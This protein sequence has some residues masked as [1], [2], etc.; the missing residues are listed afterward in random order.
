[1]LEPIDQVSPATESVGGTNPKASK[2]HQITGFPKWQ[3]WST[4][5]LAYGTP[6]M[7]DVVIYSIDVARVM[8]ELVEKYGVDSQML[9]LEITETAFL[10]KPDKYENIVSELRQKGFLVE[11]DDFGK[12]NSTL[13]FL[14]DIKADVLKI[15][16]S[17]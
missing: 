3:V 16:M 5:T 12:D 13:S 10:G 1:M 14:K 4:M 9:R 15:D 2:N 8:T 6:P 7:S 11:I 17:F